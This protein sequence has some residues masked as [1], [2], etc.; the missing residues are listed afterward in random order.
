LPPDLRRPGGG[1]ARGILRPVEGRRYFTVDRLAPRA[2]LGDWVEHYWTV[3]W[4]LPAG[5]TYTSE[6]LTHPSAHLTVESGAGERHGFVLPASLL[7]GVVTRRFAILLAGKGRV[8]GV[9][10]RPGGIGAFT[11]RDASRLTDQVV[12]AADVLG[13]GANRLKSDVLAV[14]DD[15]DRAAA[16][17]A[18]LVERMPQHDR[19]YEE[20][21]AVIAVMLADRR[22]VSVE[23][24]SRA[25]GTSPRT[26]Q[27]LFRRYVGIGPK[28]VLQRFRLQDA[29]ARIDAGDVVDLSTLAV[30]LGWYDQ[31][32]FSRDFTDVVG[33]SPGL[34][35]RRSRQPRPAPRG[36]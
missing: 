24:L 31:A 21:L 25:A 10:F 30:E 7:H 15:A 9:R 27:R 35:L 8:F 16:A 2:E 11:G 17:D 4:D 3:L 19:H 1:T 36:A 33:V 26:L 23:A 5:A 32:H 29:V 22:L 12:L 14:V 13:P 6:V 20:L 18:F 34:Y 28:W